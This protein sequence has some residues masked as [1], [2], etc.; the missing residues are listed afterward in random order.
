MCTHDASGGRS[1]ICQGQRKTV[2]RILFDSV[3]EGLVVAAFKES[4]GNLVLAGQC[5]RAD[6]M[7][8]V[9]DLH[10]IALDKNR[11]KRLMPYFDQAIDM[12]L[13]F[14]REPRRVCD[15]QRLYPHYLYFGKLTLGCCHERLS[16]R[17]YAEQES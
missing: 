17:R 10:G 14:P 15:D 12:L 2:C 4:C 8:A 13:I 1:A 7:Y 9:D 16:P 6:P 11:R 5:G 3:E